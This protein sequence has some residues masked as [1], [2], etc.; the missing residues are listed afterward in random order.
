MRWNGQSLSGAAI[1]ERE[2]YMLIPQ[3][4]LNLKSYQPGRPIEEVREELGLKQVVKLASNESPFVSTRARQAIGRSLGQINRYPEGSC[5]YLRR[6][7]AEKEG[8]SP[9][10]ILCGNGSDEIIDIIIK[11]FVGPGEEV[12]TS[13]ATFLEYEIVA[14]INNRRVTTVPLKDFRYDLEAIRKKIGRRTKVIFIAN[15]NNPTGTYVNKKEVA[16]FLRHIPASVITVFDQAYEQFV[17]VDDFPDAAKYIRGK[18]IITLH[19][20]S[21]IY[22]LAGLR[23]GYALARRELIGYMQKARLP[24]NVH[25]LAQAAARAVLDDRQYLKDTR[26][27]ILKEKEYVCGQLRKMGV[28]YIP[29]VTNFVLIDV[30]GDGYALFQRLLRQGV[31]VRDMR[32]Y[33]LNGFIRATIGR[34]SENRKFIYALKAA[35]SVYG[36]QVKKI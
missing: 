35:F 9:D 4:I 23:I 5:L 13:Q 24:F 10:N 8:V 12:L 28:S 19:T 29:S 11:A 27:A 26:R 17:D 31:I 32:Q 33:G 3:N 7:L 6:R 15:P 2:K 14:R 22:G 30:G 1:I 16:D 34:H 18:N 36:K 21:K 25:C 20:F